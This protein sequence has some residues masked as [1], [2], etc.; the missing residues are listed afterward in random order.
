MSKIEQAVAFINK[1]LSGNDQ[2]DS[3]A[4]RQAVTLYAHACCEVN[5]D[6]QHCRKLIDRGLFSDAR[7][8][9]NSMQPDLSSRCRTL[10][11]SAD[12]TAR[13]QELCRFYNYDQV[14]E[15]DRQTLALLCG[16]DDGGATAIQDLIRRWRQT[17]RTGSNIEKIRI[18]RAIL[19]AAPSDKQIW[20]SNLLVVEKDFTAQLTAEAE[21]ALQ[22]GDSA[23]LN[24]L[25]AELSSPELQIPTAP[26]ILE[27]FRPAVIEYQ[28]KQLAREAADKRRELFAAYS[29]LNQDLTRRLLNEYDVLC[30][31]PLYTP[32]SD[33]EQAVGEVRRYLA[34]IDEANRKQQEFDRLYTDLLAAIERRADFPEIENIYAALRRTDLPVDILLNK[35]IEFLRQEY[36]SEKSRTHIRKC[37]YGVSLALLLA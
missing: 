25:F 7:I 14:P 15:I 33:S 16:N 36:I 10:Q 35:R 19:A 2:S 5:K 12:K 22:S 29:S 20:R 30:T 17:A 28:K 8:Y 11:I 3:T 21:T 34:E 31:H 4:M 37:I 6:L 27:K 24:D 13:L 9:A 1:F 18:L 32:E 23:K 26:A